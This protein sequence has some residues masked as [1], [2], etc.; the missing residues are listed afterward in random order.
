MGKTFELLG[1]KKGGFS[2]RKACSSVVVLVLVKTWFTEYKLWIEIAIEFYLSS[3]FDQKTAKER[4]GLR[5]KLPP[6]TTHGRDFTL[7]LC[8]T[9]SWGAESQFFG[10]WFEVPIF[11]AFGLTQLEIEAEAT[12]SEA[13][14]LSTC[15]FIGW[16]WNANCTVIKI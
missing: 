2:S 16:F 8:W 9:S 12:V 14:A 1:S 13:D 3:C 5:V 11:R 6:V 15:S 10:V 7:S 4:F